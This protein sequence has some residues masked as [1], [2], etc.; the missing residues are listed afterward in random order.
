K[1][2]KK[3]LAAQSPAAQ[4]AGKAAK[5]YRAVQNLDFASVGGVQPPTPPRRTVSRIALRVFAKP[6]KRS[7]TN[8]LRGWGV[9]LGIS[10]GMGL[11]WWVRNSIV[12]GFPDVLGLTAHDVVVVGQL[13]TAERIADA[14]SFAAYFQAAWQTTFNSYWGQFGWMALPL[15]AWV[16]PRIGF[17]LA[18]AFT[19]VIVGLVRGRTSPPTAKQWAVG[20]LLGVTA[21]L[22]AA[23]FV[24]YNISF[25]QVQGRYLFTAIIPFALLLAYGL[26]VWTRWLSDVFSGT[27][28][29]MPYVMPMLLAGT[30][31][32][33]NLWLVRFVL[34]FLAP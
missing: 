21:L 26:N 24:Y 11:L 12:Y 5:A 28:S 22:S 15:P 1:G 3:G 31:G 10:F 14:G 32:A 18:G 2:L 4:T 27:A 30:F 34:P 23:A 29:F 9:I 13:R 25:Y 16:Y 19:G 17:M 33:F 20:A 7:R 8:I 6:I